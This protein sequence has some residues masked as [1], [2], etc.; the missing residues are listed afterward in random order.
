MILFLKYWYLYFMIFSA[1][2]DNQKVLDE[3]RPQNDET[4]VFFLMLIITFRVSHLE[5]PLSKPVLSSES[6]LDLT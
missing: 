5:S 3:S 2:E 6:S 4:Q 1:W